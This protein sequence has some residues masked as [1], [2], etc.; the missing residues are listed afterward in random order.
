MTIHKKKTSMPKPLTSLTIA[1]KIS[2]K[3]FLMLPSYYIYRVRGGEC[4]YVEEDG[5]EFFIYPVMR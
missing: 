2:R 1:E 3:Q 4:F 5:K